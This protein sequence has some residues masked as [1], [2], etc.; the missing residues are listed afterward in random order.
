VAPLQIDA[1][2]VAALLPLVGA[3]VGFVHVEQAGVRFG[4]RVIRQGERRRAA[5]MAS[6]GCTEAGL[7][8][9]VRGGRPQRARSR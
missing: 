1:F 2:A 6:S 4:K 5:R 9:P 3:S 8:E 7:P